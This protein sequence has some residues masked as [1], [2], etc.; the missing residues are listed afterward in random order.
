MVAKWLLISVAGLAAGLLVSSAE[1]QARRGPGRTP[2]ADC[3]F[4][5]T[6][7][8]PLTEVE[9][10]QIL[11]M[12]EEEKL[13][14]DVYRAMDE[15][16]QVPAFFRI[17]ESEQRHMDAMERLIV[18][19]GLADPVIDDTRG[20]FTN[21]VFVGLYGELIAAG[22]ESMVDALKV[23]ARIEEV[24]IVDLRDALSL[25]DHPDLQHVFQ[26]LM[27]ASRNHLRVFGAHFAAADETYQAQYLTQDEFDAIADSPFERGK[28]CHRNRAGRQCDWC[29]GGGS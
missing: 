23:G 9:E 20:A 6:E 25:T 24:D 8:V 10:H 26:N 3:I 4:D 11:F 21:P 19:Y 29:G 28:G 17:S 5:G 18:R 12:R 13:A 2:S 27:R 16:W 14:R 15:L 1:A 7:V 22:S